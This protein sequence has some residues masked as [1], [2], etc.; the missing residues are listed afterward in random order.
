MVLHKGEAFAVQA[1]DARAF[2]GSKISAICISRNVLRL[3][4]R[5]LSDCQS[6]EIVA[7][8][9]NS[10]LADIDT[11]VFDGCQSLRSIAIP[12]VATFEGTWFPSCR[13]LRSLTFLRP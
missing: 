6:L 11:F 12:S 10:H 7:F 5:S 1:V 2:A 3:K 4:C 9:A 8:E 13:S